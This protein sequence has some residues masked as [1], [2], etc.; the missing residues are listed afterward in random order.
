LWEVSIKYGSLDRMLQHQSAMHPEEL[1]TVEEQI[2][3]SSTE[4]RR[5]LFDAIIR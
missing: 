5:R 1:A 4:A 2:G 3:P